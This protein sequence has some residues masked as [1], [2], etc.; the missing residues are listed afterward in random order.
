MEYE[1]VIGEGADQ[2]VRCRYDIRDI[3]DDQPCPECG[4]LTSRSR[5]PT[6]RLRDSR[7]SYL[8]RLSRGVW[9]LLIAWMTPLTGF[10]LVILGNTVRRYLLFPNWVYPH[11]LLVGLDVGL[12]LLLVGVWWITRPEPHAPTA[13][14]RVRWLVRFAVVPL[15]AVLCLHASLA[16]DRFGAGYALRL[17]V[18][19]ANALDLA[20]WL[21]RAFEAA[22]FFLSCVV[23]LPLPILLF[24]HLRDLGRRLLS[25]Q[26]TEHS[27]IVGIGTSCT[28]AAVPVIIL[29]AAFWNTLGLPTLPR[30]S[31][32]PIIALTIFFASCALF[33]L[34]AVYLF[35]RFAIAFASEAR[36]MRAAWRE[37][38]LSL[39]QSQE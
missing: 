15:A 5:R 26:M 14:K 4:L 21:E 32:V 28:I 11:L 3:A 34:W 7:P 17:G 25:R 31:Q 20:Q 29:I 22:S 6:E 37:A 30:K 38:D 19:R 18:A 8:N 36:A 10:G 24:L 39:P 23:V 2:C 9:L 27:L 16:L 13:G 1:R 35:I 12:S 33:W